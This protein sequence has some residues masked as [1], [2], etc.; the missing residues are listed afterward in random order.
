MERD[1]AYCRDC[2]YWLKGISR[3]GCPECGRPF[4]WGSPRSVT[5]HPHLVRWAR[6][7]R[8][9]FLIMLP[10]TI[11]LGGG[12]AVGEWYYYRVY[13]LWERFG[14][15]PT[16]A[17]DGDVGPFGERYAYA[18]GFGWEILVIGGHDGDGVL[19][20]ILDDFGDDDV[21]LIK[22]MPGVTTL[23]LIDTKIT[24]AAISDIATLFNLRTLDLPGADITDD[25]MPAI[26]TLSNLEVLNLPNTNITDVGL[27]H[28]SKLRRLRALDIQGTKV[29]GPGLA[30]LFDLPA[31]GYV[32]CDAT[33]DGDM[34]KNLASIAPERLMVVAGKELVGPR[35]DDFD[36]YRNDKGEFG[37]PEQ[38]Q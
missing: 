38:G 18:Y 24:D 8:L 4:S 37:R 27:R 13:M 10:F 5:R 30:A 12:I 7:C 9:L 3:E 25:A 35:N 20:P 21:W 6:K 22:G 14:A 23:R 26:A 36:I 31:L 15:N 29:R 2:G 11:I 34:L 1:D 28:L 17:P 32:E 33:V 19:W 16:L